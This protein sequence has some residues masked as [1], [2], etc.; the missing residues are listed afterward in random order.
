MAKNIT[1]KGILN[2]VR[3]SLQSGK[4]DSLPFKERQ[5]A[6]KLMKAPLASRPQN[7]SD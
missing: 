2:G 3:S 7:G 6:V 4:A 5:L 1:P